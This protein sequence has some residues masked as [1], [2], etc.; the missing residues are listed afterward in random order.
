LGWTSAWPGDGNRVGRF[1]S[2][3]VVAVVSV[4]AL[5]SVPSVVSIVTVA[6]IIAVTPVAKVAERTAFADSFVDGCTRPSSESTQ[7]AAGATLRIVNVTATRGASAVGRTTLFPQCAVGAHRNAVKPGLVE[8]FSCLHV[9]TNR[10][11][12][13]ITPGVLH[14]SPPRSAAEVTFRDFTSQQQ[15]RVAV[16]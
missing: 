15:D 7:D 8:I 10:Y 3:I 4:P 6:P 1:P 12:A 14:R 16:L 11:E 2:S 13:A 9:E 5:V